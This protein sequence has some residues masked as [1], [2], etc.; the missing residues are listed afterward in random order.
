[1]AKLATSPKIITQSQLASRSREL[2]LSEF[3][4]LKIYNRSYATVENRK[5]KGIESYMDDGKDSQNKHTDLRPV[6]C[7]LISV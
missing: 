3:N 2:G 6:P 1:M 4:F 7:L 5:S